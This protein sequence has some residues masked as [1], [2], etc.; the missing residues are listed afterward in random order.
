MLGVSFRYKQSIV[1][2]AAEGLSPNFLRLSASAYR[3]FGKIFFLLTLE[4]FFSFSQHPTISGRKINLE[5]NCNHFLRE[6]EDG[7]LHFCFVEKKYPQLDCDVWGFFSSFSAIVF[8]IRNLMEAQ[9]ERELDVNVQ[10]SA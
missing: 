4:N 5:N 10:F 8:L 7:T 2:A 3:H 9:P 6:I 1:Y